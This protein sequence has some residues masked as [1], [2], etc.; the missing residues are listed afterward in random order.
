VLLLNAGILSNVIRFLPPLVMT[1]EQADY[2]MNTLEAAI[3]SALKE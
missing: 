2:V 1:D 3:A